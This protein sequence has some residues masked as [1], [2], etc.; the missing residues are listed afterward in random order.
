VTNAANI[1]GWL[2]NT[3][4]TLLCQISCDVE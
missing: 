1:I 3:Q 2:V 4:V